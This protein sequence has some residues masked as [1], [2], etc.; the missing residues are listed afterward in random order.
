MPEIVRR[1]EKDFGLASEQKRKR[2]RHVDKELVKKLHGN[3]CR[4]C[5]KTEKQVGELQMAH[6]KAHSRGGSE[7]V[8]LCPTCHR[9]YDKGL[10]K[11]GELKKLGL[12]QKDY[13]KY[14]PKK[15]KPEKNDIFAL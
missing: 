9:K 6:L 10:P 2:R 4:I 7:V 13:N 12:S 1:A 3:R 8:P 5:G 11:A 14:R 15:S